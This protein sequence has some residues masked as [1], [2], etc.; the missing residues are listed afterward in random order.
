MLA[1]ERFC[2]HCDK[3]TMGLGRLNRKR[4][5]CK[6]ICLK[7]KIDKTK[8]LYDFL[9]KVDKMLR[10]QCTSLGNK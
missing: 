7:F 8:T 1:D 2:F 4:A 5:L 10:K 6:D 9:K 3:K